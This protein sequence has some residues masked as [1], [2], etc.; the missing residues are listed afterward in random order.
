MALENF[1]WVIN[2]FVCQ[3]R[4]H[5]DCE[6][7]GEFL[8]TEKFYKIREW[9]TETYDR[10]ARQFDFHVDL[11][12]DLTFEMTRAAN[13]VCDSVRESL[14]RAFRVEQGVLLV[15]RSATDNPIPAC[16]NSWT[17][18]PHARSASERANRPSRTC[19]LWCRGLSRLE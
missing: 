3:F 11:I 6:P 18:A 9:D 5:A 7:H 8:R 4:R 12:H 15:Q 1:R 2:D 19:L 17:L 14:D 10:L 13:Y 16:K